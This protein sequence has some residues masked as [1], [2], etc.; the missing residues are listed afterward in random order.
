MDFLQ[1]LELLQYTDLYNIFAAIFSL[2]CAIVVPILSYRC[3]KLLRIME[4]CRDLLIYL[5]QA[6]SDKVISDVEAKII[7]ERILVLIDTVRGENDSSYSSDS[8]RITND[9]E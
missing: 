8:K 3:R 4:S 6:W 2:I 9:A 5:K 7:I 1:S